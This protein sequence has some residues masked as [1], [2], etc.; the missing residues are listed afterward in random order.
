MSKLSLFNSWFFKA[1]NLYCKVFSISGLLFQY[2]EGAAE[3]RI[4][5]LQLLMN[6]AITELETE[7][8]CH[9][10]PIATDAEVCLLLFEVQNFLGLLV[11]NIQI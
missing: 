7:F 1:K 6:K 9:A 4:P 8:S 5:D 11:I 2:L 10:K 3:S